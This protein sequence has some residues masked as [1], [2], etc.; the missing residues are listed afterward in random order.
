MT[1]P[2]TTFAVTHMAV[3]LAA[4]SGPAVSAADPARLKLVQTIQLDG[5]E[6]RLDHFALDV[7]GDRLFVA[8]LSNNSLDVVDLKAGKPVKQ[9]PRQGKIQGVAYAPEL[10]RIF[11]G[12]GVDGVCNV[13]D[14]KTYELLHTLKLPAADNVRYNPGTGLVYVGHGEHALTAFDAKTYEVKAT[15]KL[16]GQPEG[17]QLD[18]A[19]SRAYVNTVK[20]SAVAVVDLAKHETVATYVPATAEGLYPMVLD[21][22]TQRIYVGCRKPAVVLALD[23]R[24]GKELWTAEIPPDIDDL[25]H[26]AKRKRLYASC[27]EGFLAILEEK[28]GGRFEVVEKMPTTKLARTCLFDPASGRLFLGVSRQAG[29]PGPEIR[30]YQARP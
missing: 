20:P 12:N 18:P 16:P 23:A 13:F 4:L 5:A 2:R 24:T 27:G 8:S 14:G 26:D 7:K 1:T 22:E 21:R 15:A 9:I 25:F 19:R 3:V 28:D 11:V 17:F 10:D 30:V 29:K 6:G